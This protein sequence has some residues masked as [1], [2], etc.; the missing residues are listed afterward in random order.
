MRPTYSETFDMATIPDDVLK[1]EWARRN[2][3]KRTSYTGG[4]VWKR[5]NAAAAG[6]RC[7]RCI[8]RRAAMEAK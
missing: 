7:Q 8:N 6:C 2:A 4:V 3:R 5:H 1:S